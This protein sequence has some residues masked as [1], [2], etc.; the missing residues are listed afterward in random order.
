MSLCEFKISQSHRELITTKKR[1][2]QTQSTKPGPKPC[3][4]LDNEAPPAFASSSPSSLRSAGRLAAPDTSHCNL[5]FPGHY[6]E[7]T[8]ILLTQF[9]LSPPSVDYSHIHH[10]SVKYLR[11]DG[12]FSTSPGKLT[13][14]RLVVS[15]CTRP[16]FKP[17][18]FVMS[19]VHGP[20]VR[21]CSLYKV[22]LTHG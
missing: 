12:S 14:S 8:S 18:H 7:G 10:V 5:S 4:V 13:S 6:L 21:V 17:M 22:N 9:L 20:H 15:T 3:Q 11:Q 16:Q 19:T 2:R 1:Q